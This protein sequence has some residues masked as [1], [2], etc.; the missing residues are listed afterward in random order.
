MSVWARLWNPIPS[1]IECFSLFRMTHL[2]DLSA[3]TY[4]T[5]EQLI[6][7]HV[8]CVLVSMIIRLA[9]TWDFLYELIC[10]SGYRGGT[11][12]SLKKRLK[13]SSLCHLVS[14][15][16]DLQLQSD[17]H[18]LQMISS[19]SSDFDTCWS[20][21]SCVSIKFNQRWSNNRTEITHFCFLSPPGAAG[22]VCQCVLLSATNLAY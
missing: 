16:S 7:L 9:W 2:I 5:N 18:R 3:V 20:N 21:F 12:V 13:A 1:F 11:Q 8:P 22:G 6:V 10:V 15:F 4:D 14:V 17:L 19:S